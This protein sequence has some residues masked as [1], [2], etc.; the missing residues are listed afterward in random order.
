[1]AREISA[2]LRKHQLKIADR[3]CRM[4]ELSARAQ[5]LTVILCTAIYAGRREEP[6][7]RA[8]ADNLCRTLTRQYLGRRPSDRDFRD[9][10]ELGAAVAEHPD[11]LA[12]GITAPPILMPYT[13]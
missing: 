6:L 11:T 13:P 4:S 3:Q 7:V 1:M 2:A 8:A 9:L 5:L 10:T 12:A